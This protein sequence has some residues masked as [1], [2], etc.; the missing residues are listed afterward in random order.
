[1]REF[2]KRKRDEM[3]GGV[4]MLHGGDGWLVMVSLVKVNCDA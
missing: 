4:L 2:K 3:R 1:M